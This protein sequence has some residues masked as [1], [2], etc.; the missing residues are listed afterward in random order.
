[1]T[2]CGWTQL[3]GVQDNRCEGIAKLDRVG[4]RIASAVVAAVDSAELL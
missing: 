2:A 3:S 1:M 4:R